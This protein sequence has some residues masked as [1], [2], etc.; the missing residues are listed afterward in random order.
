MVKTEA[1]YK[2]PDNCKYPGTSIQAA[3]IQKQAKRRGLPIFLS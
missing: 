2:V 3:Q 1:S